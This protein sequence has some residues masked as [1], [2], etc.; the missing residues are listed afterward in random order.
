MSLHLRRHGGR[1]VLVLAALLAACSGREAAAPLPVTFDSARAWVR[2]GAGDSV[3]LLVELA[4]SEAQHSFGLMRRPALDS[5]SGMLFVFDS[6]QPD[7]AGFWMWRTLIPLDIAFMD[8]TGTIDTVLAMP[9]CTSP[10][11]EWC[12]QYNPGVPYSRALEVNQGWFARH[13][14]TEGDRLE[15]DTA[16]VAVPPTGAP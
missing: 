3:P 4:R 9:P 6:V 1:L 12:D 14:V 2:T 10:Y 7:S 8:S 11:P 16:R 13:G 5:T 15:V